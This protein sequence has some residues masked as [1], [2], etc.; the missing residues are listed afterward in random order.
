[1]ARG[2]HRFYVI[3]L[4]EGSI[5]EARRCSMSAAGRSRPTPHVTAIHYTTSRRIALERILSDG[6]IE[7]D[8]DTVERAIS[9][10]NDDVRIINPLRD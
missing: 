9:G 3:Y 1:M 7:I 6:C 10:A 5:L 4:F 8:S 2:N